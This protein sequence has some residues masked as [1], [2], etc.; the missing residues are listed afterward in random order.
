M[1]KLRQRQKRKR[2][3]RRKRKPVLHRTWTQR[4]VSFTSYFVVALRS[5]TC[6]VLWGDKTLPPQVIDA[7]AST[8]ALDVPFQALLILPNSASAS[9]TV[10]AF[11]ELEINATYLDS[12]LAT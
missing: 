7:I 3:K 11:H 12:T 5:N 8:F 2:R 1:R 6:T 9:K 10:E 4:P